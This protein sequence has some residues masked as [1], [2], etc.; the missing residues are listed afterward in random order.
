MIRLKDLAYLRL[1][2]YMWS[3]YWP[4]FLGCSLSCISGLLVLLIIP[5]ISIERIVGA[6]VFRGAWDVAESNVA[7]DRQTWKGR[8]G[9]FFMSLGL[10]MVIHGAGLLVSIPK[11]EEELIIVK[12]MREKE[13]TNYDY[14]ERKKPNI[15]KY[16][17]NEEDSYLMSESAD[18]GEDNNEENED[19]KQQEEMRYM[20]I[21]D[22]L[23]KY[24]DKSPVFMLSMKRR[25]YWVCQF[26]V[27]TSFGLFLNM[28]YRT[29]YKSKF[30]IA[31]PMM[32]LFGILA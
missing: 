14:D 6:N 11:S 29:F 13:G 1:R 17:N 8:I 26:L 18:P 12:N 25:V 22:L 4:A 30:L 5:Y 16:P 28:G 27:A 10:Y 9:L 21:K 7:A 15:K 24:P 20:E 2:D 32:I 31:I 3:S 23:E 19:T